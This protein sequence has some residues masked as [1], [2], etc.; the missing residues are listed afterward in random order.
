V[1]WIG[2]KMDTSRV[3]VRKPKGKGD[4]LNLGLDGSMVIKCTS[5]NKV[6][7]CGPICSA[8]GKIQLA[9]FCKSGNENSVSIKCG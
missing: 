1:A 4:C 3:S 5:E 9:G 2:E 6:G 7:G 8:A